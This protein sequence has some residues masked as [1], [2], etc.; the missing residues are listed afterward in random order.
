MKNSNK[1]ADNR[2]IKFAIEDVKKDCRDETVF[3]MMFQLGNRMLKD[4]LAP[5]PLMDSVHVVLAF[6][7][8]V[9]MEDVFP[10]DFE[11]EKRNCLIV[12]DGK[13]W[14]PLF[15]DADELGNFAETNVVEPMLIRDIIEKAID[16]EEIAG[17]V[18]NPFTD[19]FA[20]PKD[21]L[22]FLMDNLDEEDSEAC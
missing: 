3:N 13:D 6:S 10:D 4:G 20:L 2:F 22:E 19:A 12:L 11:P 1:Y 9:K 14:I 18:I 17:V 8:D 5:A 7:P 16:D 21:S 15:T